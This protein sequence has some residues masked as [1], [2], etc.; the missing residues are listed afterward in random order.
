MSPNTHC[1]LTLSGVTLRNEDADAY[2]LRVVGN[3]AGPRLGHRRGQ[4]GSGGVYADAQTLEG[5]IVV[6]T[7]PP[8]T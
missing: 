3:S 6:D 8:W 4:R 2:L 7:S 1:V 5:D